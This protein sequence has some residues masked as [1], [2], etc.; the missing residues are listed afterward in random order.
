MTTQDLVVGKEYIFKWG[1]SNPVKGL[2]LEITEF[3]IY[4]K[5]ENNPERPARWMKNEFDRN[6]IIIE[7]L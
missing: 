5:W 2:V 6:Y 1:Y 3:T 7:K 4:I